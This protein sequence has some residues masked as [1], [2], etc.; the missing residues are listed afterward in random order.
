MDP[1]YY[2]VDLVAG[3]S[4][5]F[6]V[7][8]DDPGQRTELRLYDPTGFDVDLD[9]FGNPQDVSTVAT[10]A[11]TYVLEVVAEDACTDYT[12][13]TQ[14]FGAPDCQPDVFEPN[15]AGPNAT[16]L[17]AGTYTD[18]NADAVSPDFYRFAVPAN[19]LFE[20]EVL[21]R[22]P[23]DDLDLRLTSP[24]GQNLDNAFFGDTRIVSVYNDAMFARNVILEVETDECAV[25]DLVATTTPGPQ[26]GIPDV[27]EPNQ[28]F[29][30]AFDL[31]G[32]T[33]PLD[34]LRSAPADRDRYR[35]SVPADHRLVAEVDYQA[36][37]NRPDLTLFDA[38]GFDVDFD[39]FGTTL[40]VEDVNQSATAV[41]YI[42]QVE[43][44]D[45]CTGYALSWQTI[46][47]DA[48]DML[49][50]NDVPNQLVTVVAG[51]D[52][53]VNSVSEDY[54]YVGLVPPGE[55]LTANL[56]FDHGLG[57]IDARLEDPSGNRLPG[58]T[59]GASVSD[60]ETV[61]WTNDSAVPQPA[62]LHVFLYAP[63]PCESNTYDFSVEID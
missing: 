55:T 15:D 49:E 24:T 14:V 13:T 59:G 61:V 39:G 25:Y 9:F 53:I 62:V 11:G 8:R 6:A 28:T 35:V 34:D 23:F 27:A 18:L 45:G 21:G 43:S 26:C 48:D 5:F 41:D 42:V 50:P 38:A 31:A 2:S 36:E 60:E 37:F 16:V 54:F 57:D 56:T 1:D 32:S 51:D 46:A 29:A 10:V 47:C 3:E 30:S 52:L 22:T 19:T 20:I 44:P 12:L 33:S 4:V 17:T 63:Q 40:V 58:S 7:E